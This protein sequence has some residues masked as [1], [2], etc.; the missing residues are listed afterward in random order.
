[1]A[2][3]RLIV[4]ALG[5]DSS[6][7]FTGA[8]VSNAMYVDYME[9]NDYATNTDANGNFL[10]FNISANMVIYYA[11][12]EE[13]GVSVA[14][15]MNHKNSNR[16]RWV[17]AYMGYFTSTN[18]VYPDG[19]TNTFNTALAHS[20]TLDSDGDGIPNSSDPTPIF[21]P[22]QWDVSIT[23][24]NIPPLTAFISWHSIPN[25]TNTVQY[26]TNMVTWFLL[27]NFVSPTL[28]PPAGGWPITNRIS[29]PIIGPM[30]MYHVMVYPTTTN[31]YGP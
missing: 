31:V 26:S 28:T 16:L 6:F 3:G 13:N 15:K 5:A 14:A 21:V 22:S 20:P 27:T 17:P 18:Y 1:M 23:T 30:R 25:A 8:G 24:T 11:D 19:T 10:A 4:D 29:D 9:L 2:I 12:A 7:Q